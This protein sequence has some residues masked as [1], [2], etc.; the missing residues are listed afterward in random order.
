MR[1]AI[2]TPMRHN[3][4]GSCQPPV[5]TPGPRSAGQLA[6]GLK[7][8]SGRT[9]AGRGHLIHHHVTG[10]GKTRDRAPR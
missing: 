6:D 8:L 3:A 7:R 4:A 1:G 9:P 5:R 2:I 10:L